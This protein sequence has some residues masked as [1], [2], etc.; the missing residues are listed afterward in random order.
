MKNRTFRSRQS[1]STRRTRGTTRL[2]VLGAAFMASTAVSGPLSTTLYAQGTLR[3]TRVM[4][5]RALGSSIVGNVGEGQ[6]TQTAH[7]QYSGRHDRGCRRSV[8]HLDRDSGRF[9]Q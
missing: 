9:R 5:S 7:V 1:V 6:G 2:F 4:T 3:D 8:P